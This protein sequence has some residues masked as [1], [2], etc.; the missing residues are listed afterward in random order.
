ML[1][2]VYP[3]IDSAYFDT[4]LQLLRFSEEL[5]SGGARLVQFRDKSG[6]TRL[7]LERAI[8]LARHA[9]PE[10]RLILNDRPDLCVLAGFHGV[11]VGQD[12]LS[13]ASSRRV[14]G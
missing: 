12:D 13:V 14:V 3:I 1:P 8:E 7:F 11:H 9:H 2:R 4:T 6:M 5:Q 10:T